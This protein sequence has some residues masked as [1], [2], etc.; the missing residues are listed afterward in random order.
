MG[1]FDKIVAFDSYRQRV[2]HAPR[3]MH[4]KTSRVQ[5]E[6]TCP[7]FSAIGPSTR[8]G[9]YHSLVAQ[10]NAMP[11]CLRVTA[12]AEDGEVMAVS[13]V[14]HPTFGLQFHPESILTTE[15]RAMAEGFMGVVRGVA[16]C[17]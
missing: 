8:V 4:G 15:G 16:R 13:H 2:T 5:V 3:I 1:A 10:E 12:R 11:S 7:L 9:R 14:E 17:V 6:N